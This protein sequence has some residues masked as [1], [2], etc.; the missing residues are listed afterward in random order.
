MINPYLAPVSVH[1]QLPGPGQ[2]PGPGPGRGAAPAQTARPAP[3]DPVL[4]HH[5]G[6]TAS[7]GVSCE[8][9]CVADSGY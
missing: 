1:S 5:C 2:P 9:M 8:G 7:N 3:Q 4:C 6:R